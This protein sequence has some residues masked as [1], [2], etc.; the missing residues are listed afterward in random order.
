MSSTHFSISLGIFFLILKVAF[1]S[2][3]IAFAYYMSKFFPPVCH[4]SFHFLHDVLKFSHKLQKINY[5]IFS[6]LTSSSTSLSKSPSLQG[7]RFYFNRVIIEV[8][9]EGVTLEHRTGRT[10]SQPHT[11]LRQNHYKGN[12]KRNSSLKY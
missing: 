3:T 12:I 4:L 7:E 8:L 10:R 5:E 2:K 1:N 6:F 9:F 11:Y